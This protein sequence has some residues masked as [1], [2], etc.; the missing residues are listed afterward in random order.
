MMHADG[1]RVTS[2]CS[3]VQWPVQPL[4]EL[5]LHAYITVYRRTGVW[6]RLGR[7]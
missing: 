1:V 2:S 4:V 5:T 6:N 3:L 7:G